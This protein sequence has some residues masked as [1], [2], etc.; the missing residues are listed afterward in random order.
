MKNVKISRVG[1]KLLIEIDLTAQTSASK[2]GKTEIIASTEGNVI[3]P[4]EAKDGKP[5][6]LGLNL[7][8]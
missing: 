7:Y 4:G 8:K 6:R 5:I 2:S 1:D 3:I